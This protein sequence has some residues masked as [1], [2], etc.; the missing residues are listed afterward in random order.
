MATRREPEV[1]VFQEPSFK[2]RKKGREAARERE[3]FLVSHLG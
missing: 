3:R 1:I 2:E